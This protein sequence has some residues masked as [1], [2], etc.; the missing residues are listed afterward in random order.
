MTGCVEHIP[1][2]TFHGRKGAVQNS[3]RYSV[4]Y[5]MLDPEAAQAAPRLFSRNRR[6]VM[7]FVERDH[8][9]APGKGRGAE[10]LRDAFCKFQLPQPARISLLTQP[11]LFGFVFNPVSF[12]FC[13][14]NTG[15]LYAVVA[16]VTNTFGTRHSYLCH[17]PDLSA[18]GPSDRL[19]ATKMLHVSPFQ[20]REGGYIFRFD[21]RDDRV[22]VWIDYGRDRGG[23]IATLT[24]HRSKLDNKAILWS[25]LRRP[26]G[27]RRVR[28]LIHW[29]AVKLWFKGATFRSEPAPKS[30]DVSRG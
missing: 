11:R 17:K 6:N 2:F 14:A 10:W 19:A 28:A 20:P 16:E 12:W 13:F 18:I 27:S 25:A 21:L 1:A 30:P 8:G 22:G 26:F 24:G 3:F 7:S 23:L 29:Q 15:D 4:D 5:V 9:G